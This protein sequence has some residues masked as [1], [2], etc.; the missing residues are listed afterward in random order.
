MYHTGT[1]IEIVAK[2]WFLLKD[3][4]IDSVDGAMK[5]LEDNGVV[6]QKYVD[7]GLKEINKKMKN[8]PIDPIDS[9]EAY[10]EDNFKYVAGNIFQMD[11]QSLKHHLE[12]YSAEEMRKY[13]ERSVKV[14]K[15]MSERDEFYG[16]WLKCPNCEAE[17]TIYGN[18]FCSHCG[19]KLEYTKKK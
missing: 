16:D 4:S 19:V 5:Y 18:N 6:I 3:N 11:Y 7:K 1:P 9:T 13:M 12:E 17:C 8:L 15:S 14:D 2:E 10:I